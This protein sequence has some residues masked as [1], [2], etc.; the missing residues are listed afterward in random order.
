MVKYFHFQRTVYVSK[1]N[2][3]LY[4]CILL[5]FPLVVYPLACGTAGHF[6]ET[7]G[8]SNPIIIQNR[9]PPGWNHYSSVPLL[10]AD[11]AAVGCKNRGLRGRGRKFSGRLREVKRTVAGGGGRKSAKTPKIKRFNKL[12]NIHVIRTHLFI[13]TYVHTLVCMYIVCARHAASSAR[14]RS[15]AEGAQL[16]IL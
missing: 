12:I 15:P 9:R 1:E 10:Y 3:R 2:E 4:R 14:K 11:D 16:I 5:Q 6:W 13:Y 8:D 7:S